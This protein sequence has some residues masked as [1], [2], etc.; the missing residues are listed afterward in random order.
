M[1]SLI[2]LQNLFLNKA[3]GYTLPWPLLFKKKEITRETSIEKGLKIT[4]DDSDEFLIAFGKEFN[5]DVSKFPIGD[6]FGDE[7]DPILPAIIRF[8]TGKKKRQTKTITIGQLEKAVI[9]GRLDEEV[10]NS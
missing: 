3:L 7:G 8:L 5:V 1:K 9:A 10:I 2:G 6:Y 4:G